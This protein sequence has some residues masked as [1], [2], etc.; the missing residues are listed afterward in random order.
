MGTAKPNQAEG[1]SGR[2]GSIIRSFG[3]FAKARRFGRQLLVALSVAGALTF[4]PVVASADT[5][6]TAINLDCGD[7][8]PLQAIVDLD[9]LSDVQA[10]VNAMVNYPAGLTCLLSTTAVTD[11]LA[12]PTKGDPFIVGGGRYIAVA[13]G[14]LN[15][16]TGSCYYNFGVSAHQDA[17]GSTHGSSHVVET[18]QSPNGTCNSNGGE[19]HANVTCVG[20]PTA[21]TDISGNAITIDSTYG[22]ITH[23]TGDY[24][25]P[26]SM[27]PTNMKTNAT[28][29]YSLAPN[30]EISH[31]FDTT[32]DPTGPCMQQTAG[33][34]PVQDGKIHMGTK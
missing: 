8:F 6:L 27:P 28:A 13:Q 23:A 31:R 14:G 24:A 1:R 33:A 25:Q 18:R 34:Y 20:V 5:G 19:V 22:T 12:T 15:P 11:P 21:S 4:A 30:G 16:G 9:T 7:G 10:A 29:P 2:R 3:P 26:P 32:A 17:D